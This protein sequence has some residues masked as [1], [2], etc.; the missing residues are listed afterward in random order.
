ML[1]KKKTRTLEENKNYKYLG[2][3]EADTIK[4]I[5]MKEKIKKEDHQRTRKLPK[6]KLYNRNLSKG[7]NTWAVPLVKYSGPFFKWTK[8]KLQ[9]IHQRTRKLMKMYLRNDV[10]R[11]NMS[12]KEGGREHTNTEDSDKTT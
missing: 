7:I 1:I 6:T 4:E 2:I 10:D 8:E 9:Q 12:G 3:L 11:L 5:E